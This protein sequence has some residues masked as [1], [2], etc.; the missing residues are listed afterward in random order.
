MVVV[1][2]DNSGSMRG[3]K[4]A[5]AVDGIQKMVVECQART[6]SGRSA[7]RVLLIIF[8]SETW[9]HPQCKLTP[10]MEVVPEN[11]SFTGDGGQTNMNG[12]LELAYD[13]IVDY[14][15]TIEDH[16]KNK[17][18]RYRSY[19]SFPMVTTETNLVDRNLRPRS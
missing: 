16:P 19:F 8:G 10:V 15:E 3:K 11:I 7:F 4:A 18:I 2:A 17:N 12:A 5:A 6:G 14:L 13:Q 9:I 1:I